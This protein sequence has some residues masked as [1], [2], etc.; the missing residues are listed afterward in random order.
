MVEE[1]ECRRCHKKM[2]PLGMPFEAYNHVGKWRATEND[3]PVDTA[4]AIKYTGD[5]A[6]EGEVQ[7][8][9]AMMEKIA[10]SGLARPSLV[11][12]AD[13]QTVV[14]ATRLCGWWGKLKTRAAWEQG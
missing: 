4:G 7:N 11:V 10:R 2:N 14:A 6:M 9:R 1:P 12:H 3:K 8:V 13:R 5:K